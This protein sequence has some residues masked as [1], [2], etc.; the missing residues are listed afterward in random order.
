MAENDENM[1]RLLASSC[2]IGQMFNRWILT[3]LLTVTN[4]DS[5][6]A[7]SSSVVCMPCFIGRLTCQNVTDASGTC[8]NAYCNTCSS[9]YNKALRIATPSCTMRQYCVCK[10]SVQ[11]PNSATGNCQGCTSMIANCLSCS[12]H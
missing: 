3:Y 7:T 9:Q 10:V 11:Y 1:I 8:W 2:P 5:L 4:R 6:T 12:A